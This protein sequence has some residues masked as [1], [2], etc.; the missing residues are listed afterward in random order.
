MDGLGHE[1]QV[2]L[3]VEIEDEPALTHLHSLVSDAA[4]DT[5]QAIVW[6]LTN[7]L[8]SRVFRD[9]LA[10]YGISVRRGEVRIFSQHASP[11]LPGA[12]LEHPIPQIADPLGT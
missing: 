7:A 10:E 11:V 2:R 1:V 6:A 8:D 9:L 12:G 4:P 5:E 3:G